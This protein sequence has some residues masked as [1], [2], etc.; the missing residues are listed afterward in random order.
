MQPIRMIADQSGRSTGGPSQKKGMMAGKAPKGF[1]SPSASRGHKAKG[2]SAMSK[3]CEIGINAITKMNK[4]G[5][6]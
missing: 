6:H 1:G 4:F 5:I 3:K 2:Q